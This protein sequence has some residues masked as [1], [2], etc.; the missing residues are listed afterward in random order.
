MHSLGQNIPDMRIQKFWRRLAIVLVLLLLPVPAY[1]D[2]SASTNYRVDQTFFGSGGE[3][4]AC[5]GTYCSKQ[6]LGELAV[7]ST[8]SAHFRAYAGFNTTDAPY[9]EMYVTPTL[10]DLGVLDSSNPSTTT[11]QFYIRAWQAAGYSVINAAGPPVND[12]G[13]HELAPLTS[14]GTSSPGTEQFGINLVKNTDFCGTGCDLTNSA[15]PLQVP[16]NTFA[17][18]IV[19]PGYDTANTFKYNAGDVIARSTESTSRTVFTVSYLYN[20]SDVTP[21]GRYTFNHIMV[22]IGSY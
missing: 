1:A 22:A 3:L 11:A 8:S 17:F 15:D 10:T 5:S 14:G 18:G 13:G 9:I 21:A 16:D 2:S 12:T 19:E 4:N 7:G 6:T 20:I